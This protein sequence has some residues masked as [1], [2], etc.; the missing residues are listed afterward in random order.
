MKSIKFIVAAAAAL[1]LASNST[2]ASL[3]VDDPALGG[4]NIIDFNAETQ[5]SFT[6]RTFDSFVTFSGANPLY[7]ENTYTSQ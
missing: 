4:F 1:T 5:G 2:F 6:S 7:I 3:T